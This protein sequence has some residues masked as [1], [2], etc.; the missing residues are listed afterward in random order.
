MR[1]TRSAGGCSPSCRPPTGCATGSVSCGSACW[2]TGPT[3]VRRSSP[4]PASRSSWWS[5]SPCAPQGGVRCSTMLT[6][7]A[8]RPSRLS[9]DR[10]ATRRSA[11]ILLVR[12]VARGEP[13]FLLVHPGGPFW[14]NKD[15]GA[16]SIPKGEYEE[17]DDPRACAL[18][19]FE[20]E[21]GT[22]ISD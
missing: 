8:T 10:M 17:A 16:W 11:G 9:S 7:D 5:L 3:S 2:G 13:E 20:E 4:R 6:T 21:L 1:R 19:E 15:D 12:G 22:V 18:R 14:A